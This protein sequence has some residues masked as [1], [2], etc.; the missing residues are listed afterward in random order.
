EVQAT[1]SWGDYVTVPPLPDEVFINEKAQFDPKYRNVQ[2]QRVPGRAKLLVS[3]PRNGRG[4]RMIVEGSAGA[5]RP[6]GARYIEA[7]ARQYARAQADGTVRNVRAI[8]VMVVNRRNNTR[9]RFSDVTFAFQVRLEVRSAH[10]LYP[11]ANVTGYA[12]TD[13]DAAVADLH[14]SDV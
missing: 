12:S 1:L 14:Y 13:F 7:N 3:V 8:T 11:R 5:Q 9:R 2:W 4:R 10:G 6:G